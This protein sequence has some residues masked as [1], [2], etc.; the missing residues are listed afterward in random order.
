MRRADRQIKNLSDIELIISRCDVCRIA[1][2]D[3]NTPYIVT[4]NFGHKPGDKSCLYFHCAPEGK[5]IDLISRNNY[6]C[7][8]MDTDHKLYGGAEGCDWGMNYSSII[9]YGRIHIIRDLT[10]KKTGLDC[11][12]AHYTGRDG[13]SYDD[14]IMNSTTVLRLD[15]EEI[16]GK[17]K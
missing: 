15:I 17:Q 7:F 12:M 9:G 5:K 3:L 14:K 4:M 1:F 6:V 10:E 16:T 8:E 13:F 2:A 11:I